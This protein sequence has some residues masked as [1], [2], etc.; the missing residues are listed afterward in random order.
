VIGVRLAQRFLDGRPQRGR[1]FGEAPDLLQ[2]LQA[3]QPELALLEG[4]GEE[5][6]ERV[7]LGALRG[8]AE[9][10]PGG[11]ERFDVARVPLDL[12]HPERLEVV[13]LFPVNQSIRIFAERHGREIL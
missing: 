6:E 9:G 3:L 5:A 7:G 11:D 1:M 2:Y 4:V 13:E 12:L 10:F 8:F